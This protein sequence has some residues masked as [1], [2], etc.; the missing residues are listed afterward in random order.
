MIISRFVCVRVNSDS[1]LS[2]HHTSAFHILPSKKAPH[3]SEP[4]PCYFEFVRVLNGGEGCVGV[5]LPKRFVPSRYRTW[6]KG[7]PVDPIGPTYA[8]Y[9]LNVDRDGDPK[10]SFRERRRVTRTSGKGKLGWHTL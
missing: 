1:N 7:E 6:A 10:E 9:H 5:E 4:T 2:G 8:L 3:H